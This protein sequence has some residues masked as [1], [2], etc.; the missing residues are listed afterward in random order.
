MQRARKPKMSTE[1]HKMSHLQTSRMLHR[2]LWA[3]IGLVYFWGL[4]HLFVSNPG[5]FKCWYNSVLPEKCA[6]LQFLLSQASPWQ[7]VAFTL[8]MLIY[9]FLLWVGLARNISQFGRV[10]S[11]LVQA[12]CVFAISLIVR[13]DNVVL[14]LYLVLTLAAI[15]LLQN[16]RLALLIASSSL[17]LFIFN[18]LLS[19]GVL[20]NWSTALWG[21]WIS[22]DYTA[23]SLF[24]VGYL[25][26]YL[27]SSRTYTQLVSTYTEL[28]EAH[29]GLSTASR[30]IA[31]LTRLAERQRLARELHD[32]LSQGL[33]GLKLQLE[34]V[35]ALLT[36]RQSNQAQEI[37]R[38]AMGHIQQTLT[39]ARGAIDDLRKIPTAQI[40]EAVQ[41]M[42]Q[43]FTAATG[44]ACQTDLTVLEALPAPF[45][46]PL[47]RVIGEGLTNIAR[48]ARARH[49]WITASRTNELVH[50]ELRDNG[51]GFD[52]ATH[53][54][55]PGHYGLL[56]LRERARLLG[57]ELNIQST[58]GAGTRIGFSFP[59]PLG[60]DTLPQRESMEGEARR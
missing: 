59:L 6:P 28:D 43:R 29:R 8:L 25:L 35:D 52:L 7:I 50:L 17:L 26:L 36:Q 22:T 1:Q 20:K 39:Q 12:S 32:T 58:P 38:Q 41:E 13:Q 57:G 44:I 42:V 53:M 33:V 5:V 54:S 2:F 30:Q 51:A 4:F 19:H 34:A 55:Q 31:A 27:Q 47:L 16:T 9:G 15:D 60:N 11:F 40:I 18:E 45:H 37:V 48:H 14:S 21:I 56:G 23:L 49:V 24:L 10:L 46:E 3:W